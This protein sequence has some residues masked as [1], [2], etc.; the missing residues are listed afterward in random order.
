MNE[1][2]DGNAKN[3]ANLWKNFF[4]YGMM[5][6]FKDVSKEKWDENTRDSE[7][8]IKQQRLAI[9]RNE[10]VT[11]S[12]SMVFTMN[13]ANE[14]GISRIDRRR[15]IFGRKTVNEKVQTPRY[16][17]KNQNASTFSKNHYEESQISIHSFRTTYLIS[18]PVFEPWK[19]FRWRVID[20]DCSQ[21]GSRRILCR[22]FLLLNRRKMRKS[23]SMVGSW[24]FLKQ[25]WT[26]V[27]LMQ[28]P[29]CVLPQISNQP[30]A[31]NNKPVTQ[32]LW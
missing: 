18:E 12:L 30:K 2:G 28:E 16:Y 26:P 22:P 32:L 13:K 9:T 24:K 10:P 15:I 6:K 5:S 1:R 3:F 31:G 19:M 20:W 29:P 8:I 25:S 14:Y 11:A 23:L 4:T 7:E 21:C 17:I 27:L